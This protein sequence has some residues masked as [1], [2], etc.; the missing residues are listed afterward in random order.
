MSG[1]MPAADDD[2]ERLSQFGYRQELR[3]ALSLFEN[4]AVAFCYLSPMVGIYSLFVLGLGSAGPRYLW[5]MPIVVLG[6]L[7]VALV[8]AE[9]GSHYPVAGALFQWGKNLVGAGYGWWVGWIYGWALIVTVASVDTGIVLYAGPLINQYFHTHINVVDP[10]MVLVFT[11]AL[12]AIQTFFNIVGVRLLGLISRIGV[13]VEILGTFGIAVVLGVAGFHHGLGFLFETHGTEVAKTNPLGVDFGGNWW[14]GAA[15]V[16]VL[17]HVYIFYGFES[18]GDVAEEVVH[19]SR[20]VPRAIIS[21][22]LVGG[23]SSFILVGALTLAIPG[24][25]KGFAQAASFAGGVSYIIT[26]DISSQ[27]LQTIILILVCF[28]FFSCGTAVQAAGA[29]VAFSYARDGAL[30]GS[31]A[32]RHVSARFRTP[33]NALLLAAIIPALFALLVHYSPTKPIQVG[34]IT[35]PANVNALTL[36]VSF[37][38]SGIYLAFLLV[39]LGALIARV[40]GWRAEGAFRLGAWAY[41][42]MIGALVY[43][44]AMLLNILVPT[45]INSPKGTL[46]N[47]DWMTLL[48]MVLIVV[49]GAVYFLLAR[50]QVKVRGGRP[51]N[52]AADT[53][54]SQA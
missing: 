26:S 23:I 31:G 53:V 14:L 17:A 49:V 25:A 35:Y 6:Q 50:P 3:R 16:A 8:F 46:F 19:A 21:S 44:V 13:Y 38:V 2:S 12:L 34:F 54:P 51:G 28:A 37:G 30:P 29:R 45:G 24:G 7:L 48:V 32:I 43:G 41:P 22:L 42:V 9:L 40:R 1:S 36:L 39:V 11:L 47:Y 15:L 52:G 33:V 18:A 4:F 5:L 20:R 27:A 10:N